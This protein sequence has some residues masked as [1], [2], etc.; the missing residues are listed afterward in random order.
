M[1]AAAISAIYMNHYSH[2][3]DFFFWN[4][5]DGVIAFGAV[6]VANGLLYRRVMG[7][8]AAVGP[9]NGAPSTP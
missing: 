1:A 2:P 4:I 9:D 6:A 8:A 7:P 3:R 5:L